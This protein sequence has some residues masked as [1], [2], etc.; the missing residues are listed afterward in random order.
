VGEG[1]Y[2]FIT[3]RRQAELN[4]AVKEIGRNVTAVQGDVANLGD[5]RLFATVE[6]EKARIDILFANA[7]T[8]DFAALGEITPEHFDKIFGTNVRGL[9]FTVQKALPFIPARFVRHSQC[10]DLR[11]QGTTPLQRLLRNQGGVAF[12]R[13]DL[14]D[15]PE[16]SRHPR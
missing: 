4:S 9:L 3:G 13:T 14:D 16:G 6:A 12:I 7:G 11:E 5:L 2:V 1:A 8:A 15:G 10:L